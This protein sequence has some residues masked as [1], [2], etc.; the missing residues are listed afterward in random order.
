MECFSLSLYKVHFITSMRKRTNRVEI[1][2]NDYEL[3]HLNR[4]VKE[5]NLSRES[6]LRMCINGLVPKPSPSTELIETIGILR[7]IAKS[8]SDISK[9][10]STQNGIDESMYIQNFELL[11]NQI[12]K[13]MILIREPLP[14]HIQGGA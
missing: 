14:I 1:K 2:L 13:I 5:S 9:S 7:E 4:L 12:N 3:N 8:L 10:V 6:Y 11:Q